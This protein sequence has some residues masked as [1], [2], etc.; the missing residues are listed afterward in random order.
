MHGPIVPILLL[1][2]MCN[3]CCFIFL[4]PEAFYYM[5]PDL[6]LWKSK[7]SVFNI[8]R[9]DFTIKADQPVGNY[10]VRSETLEVLDPP[11]TADSIL[12]YD[13]A[14]A[15]DPITTRRQCTEANKC[16]V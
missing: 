12:R 13:G 4:L 10:W 11:H 8:H 3:C 1:L 7:L 15:E 16:D 14:P 5:L 6:I 2:H 9:F